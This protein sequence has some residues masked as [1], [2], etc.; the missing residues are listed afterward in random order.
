MHVV[1]ASFSMIWLAREG[2][3]ERENE[4]MK[5][6]L[7]SLLERQ[8]RACGLISDTRRFNLCQGGNMEKYH[9]KETSFYG[10]LIVC[11]VALPTLTCLIR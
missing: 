8:R 5:H 3:E 6:D 10:E 11:F 4:E 9:S 7:A 2:E 1:W